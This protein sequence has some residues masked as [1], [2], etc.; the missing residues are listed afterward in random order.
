MV[1]S[2]DNKQREMVAITESVMHILEGEELVAG[3]DNF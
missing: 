3:A 2:V 1:D